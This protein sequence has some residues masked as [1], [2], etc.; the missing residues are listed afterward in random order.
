[1]AA[2]IADSSALFRYQGKPSAEYALLAQLMFGVADRA[3]I[4][5]SGTAQTASRPAGG[6]PGV[7]VSGVE[8]GVTA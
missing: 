7:P 2:M 6:V 4:S 8:A 3:Q 5:H 1:M